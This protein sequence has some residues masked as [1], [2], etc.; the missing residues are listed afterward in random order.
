M[1]NLDAYLKR[2]N[3]DGP[4]DATRQTLFALH[5]AHLLAV[6]FENLDI[7]LGRPIILGENAHFEK[8][9]THRRGGFCFEQ[10][11]LFAAILRQ[12]GFKVTLMEARVQPGIGGS[13]IAFGHLTLL[14]EVNN[15]WLVDVGFGE[16]F[17]DPLRM[18]FPAA[19][20]QAG[21]RAFRVTHNNTQGT[22]AMKDER[23]H[24][25]YVFFFE[26][27]QLEDFA[28]GCHFHQTSPLSGFTQKRVCSIATP[29]GRKTI[30]DHRFIVTENGAREERPIADDS[31][32]HA[33]LR[34]H[35]GMSL[36]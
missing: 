5:R 7:H 14:V 21:N 6:P 10:N 16:G 30:S 15:R 24:D 8:I 19:Q 13:G 35:F 9:V 17:I 32:F 36:D 34:E 28:E 25:Q 29:Q 27:R 11:G 1:L 2:I 20:V 12:M 33:L 26:P 22:Y 4:R 18:D 31:D 23:W 3:Y